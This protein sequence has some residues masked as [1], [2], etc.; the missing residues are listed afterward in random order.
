MT[1]RDLP[2]N[3][4]TNK[5][6]N[7]ANDKYRCNWCKGSDLYENYHD[8]EWGVPLKDP[9]A[10][11]KLL[12]LEGM[13]AGLAWIT[14]LTKREHMHKLFFGFD[15]SKLSVASADDVE[16][17]LM[18]AR[19]IRHRGKLNAMIGNAQ[20]ALDIED[21]SRFLWQFAPPERRTSKTF[22]V[23]AQTYESNLMSK[24]L[25]TKGFRF[26][27]PTICYAFMQSAGMV[28]D[29]H[30]DC[31]RHRNCQKLLKSAIAIN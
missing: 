27:G 7:A 2:D 26:V 15:M 30:P 31:W 4:L 20:R 10:L 5:S 11:F 16:S 25:K 17:W 3:S 6:K 1:A 14:V 12:I 24:A 8:Q 19:I 23:P 18:D 29:H 28:N 21:F 22:N 13:Q 9:E